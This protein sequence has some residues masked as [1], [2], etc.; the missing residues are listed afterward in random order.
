VI[1]RLTALL[2]VLTSAWAAA[3]PQSEP[4]GLAPRATLE[5]I[6]AELE[7]A[8]LEG[9]AHAIDAALRA[10]PADPAL[11]NMTGVLAARRGEFGAAVAAFT[12][13]IRLDPR[14][15]A[16]YENLGRLYQE[17]SA[18][19][20]AARAKALSIYRR[21]LEIDP[22]NA[23]GLYQAAFLLALDGR[24]A[25]ANAYVARLPAEIRDAAQV[26]A[27]AATTN[28]GAGD[29]AAA[30]G[31]VQRLGSHPDL[32]AAD[33]MALVPA[34]EHLPD[35]VVAQQLLETLDRR[36][37]ATPEA[38]QRLGV[39]YFEHGQLQ[40]AIDV[41]NRAIGEGGPTAPALLELARATD[42]LGD[43][44]A[45]LG[46]LAHARSLT[47][48]DPAVHFLFGIV[49]IELNLGAEAYESLKKAVAL[50][51]ESAPVNYALG[52]VSLHRHEP[53]EAVPYFEKYV[54]LMPEDPRGRFALGVARFSINDFE[55]ARRDLEHVVD[56]PETSAGAHYFLARIARQSNDLNSARQHID[57]VLRA[58]P[59]YPDAWAELGLLQTRA[60]EYAEAERSLRKAL[61][62]DADNYPATVNLAALY[63]RTRDPRR[64]AQVAR[65]AELQQKRGEQA[66]DFLRTIQV[67][68]Q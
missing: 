7:R 10:H 57:A 39:L 29:G 25:D 52:A 62:L 56:R 21:L 46:Y 49:C 44:K 1:A 17:H 33:V 28:A 66:Q 9:A 15:A 42:K 60:G 53:S 2:L 58:A 30:T 19:E 63:T 18:T 37:I 5:A 34:F 43:H 47:P 55:G 12:E 4:A 16:A 13:A 64:E 6:A 65:L 26:L 45:A 8:D 20:P 23:E 68:P 67:V 50:A 24:F 11:H 14:L 41:L 51:P 35:D 31:A 38:L 3:A 40:E 36:G 61:A 27:L 48:D 59:Q 32:S 54:S 22:A